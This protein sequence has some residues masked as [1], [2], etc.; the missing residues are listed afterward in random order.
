MHQSNFK[1][2]I[3]QTI[4]PGGKMSKSLICTKKNSMSHFMTLDTEAEYTT[5]NIT[6]HDK[7]KETNHN[8]LMTI[9]ENAKKC[10]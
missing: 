8:K 1:I 6:T 10:H 3:K 5:F 2:C 7:Q 9:N 4:F